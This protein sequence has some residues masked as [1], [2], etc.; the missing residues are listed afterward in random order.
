[1]ISSALKGS[2]VLVAIGAAQDA[3]EINTHSMVSVFVTRCR[4]MVTSE[5]SSQFLLGLYKRSGYISN[6]SY[7]GFYRKLKDTPVSRNVSENASDSKKAIYVMVRLF[8]ECVD[9][10]R[11]TA[12]VNFSPGNVFFDCQMPRFLR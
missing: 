4:S 12:E 2:A 8:S 3:P 9:A 11:A 5:G 7:L 6:L 10:M 1:M